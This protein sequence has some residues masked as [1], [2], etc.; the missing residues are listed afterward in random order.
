M[1]PYGEGNVKIKCQVS[2]TGRIVGNCREYLRGLDTK[3]KFN[4]KSDSVDAPT[5]GRGH[6]KKWSNDQTLI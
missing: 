5:I 4:T 1:G 3:R 2:N 6:C